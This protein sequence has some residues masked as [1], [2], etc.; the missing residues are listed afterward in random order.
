MKKRVFLKMIDTK[1]TKHEQI[2]NST[3]KATSN[4][5]RGSRKFFQSFFFL[6]L[7]LMSGSKYQ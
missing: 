1:N 4:S 3:N 6:L 5:M 7:L 2:N